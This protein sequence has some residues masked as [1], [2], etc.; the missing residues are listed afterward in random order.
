MVPLLVVCFLQDWQSGLGQL[1]HA[2]ALAPNF[3]ERFMICVEETRLKMEAE[4]FQGD[5]ARERKMDL[6]EY[7]ELQSLV[8]AV[9]AT[10]RAALLA[11]RRFW[12]LLARDKIAFQS[13]ASALQEMETLELRAD[14]AYKAALEKHPRNIQ[15]MRLCAK[16]AE[17]IMKDPS[18]AQQLLTEAAKIEDAA[19]AE[20]AE[21]G[22][23]EASASGTAVNEK[24]DAIV[25]ITS[26]G[27]IKIGNRNLHSMFGFRY[28]ELV[29]AST[30][31]KS[32]L[33]PVDSAP[34]TLRL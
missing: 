11:N 13:L 28:N 4:R 7:V 3:R 17:E 16:F 2:K 26:T 15:L 20:E 22:G 12:R 23:D 34:G 9:Q 8:A 1:E 24:L 30:T 31:D 14:R 10:H 29:R 25:V 32:R 19:A 33:L 21:E 18:R 27:T 5:G 6:Q